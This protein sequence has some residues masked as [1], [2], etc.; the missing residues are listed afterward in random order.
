MKLAAVSVLAAT[1]VGP[2]C[3]APQVSDRQLVDAL[4]AKG[5]LVTPADVR[6]IS[7]KSAVEA[8]GKY[9]CDWRQRSGN[10]WGH[11][12]ALLAIRHD[13]RIDIG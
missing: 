11:R 5:E 8:P 13:G 9:H 2:A 4:K 1:L 12:S 6:G 3:A 7:C 10:R